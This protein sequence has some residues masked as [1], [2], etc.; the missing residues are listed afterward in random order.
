MSRVGPAN[1]DASLYRGR[2]YLATAWIAWIAWIE[3]PKGYH[4]DLIGKN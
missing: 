4:V 3:L 1:R 2:I